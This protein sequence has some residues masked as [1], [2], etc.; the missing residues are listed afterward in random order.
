MRAFALCPNSGEFGYL[1]ETV[2]THMAAPG[3][4]VASQSFNLTF[5]AGI[6]PLLT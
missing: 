5:S 2:A 3:L 4:T 1:P 6:S